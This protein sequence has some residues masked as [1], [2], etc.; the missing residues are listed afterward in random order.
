[1]RQGRRA[2]G[3]APPSATPPAPAPTAYPV[4][5]VCLHPIRRDRPHLLGQVELRPACTDHLAGPRG[6][7]DGE[8]ESQ[9]GNAWLSPQRRHE[10]ADVAPRQCGVVLHL[11]YLRASREQVVEMPAPARG[12][13]ARSPFPGPGIVED[14]LHATAHARRGFWFRRPDRLQCRQHL[15]RA[16][17]SNREV[18]EVWKCIVSSVARHWPACLVFRHPASCASR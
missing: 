7:E 1:M 12:V 10:G 11:G 3:A 2:C 5:T 9:R 6:S 16:N 4:F 13:L 17:A 18:A 8:L 14:R 15:R